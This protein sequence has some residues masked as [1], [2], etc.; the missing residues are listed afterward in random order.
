MPVVED[1]VSRA[2]KPVRRRRTWLASGVAAVTMAA[3]GVAI[4]ITAPS[5]TE[6][7]GVSTPS[8]SASTQTQTGA[9]I[10]NWRPVDIVGFDNSALPP[11]ALPAGRVPNITFTSDGRWRGS[12]GCNAISGTYS[13]SD[14]G[15]ISTANSAQTLIGC[16]DV[17]TVPNSEVLERAARFA[18]DGRS[19]TF[20]AAGGQRLG[21]YE[22]V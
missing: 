12:D 2:A 20:Y 6:T 11:P 15:S 7:A 3:V 8:T 16:P 21:T 4:A 19:L 5:G 10:G 1:L 22:R 9:L 18:I 17:I 13:A 14:D